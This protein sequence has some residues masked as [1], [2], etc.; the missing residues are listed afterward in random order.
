RVAAPASVA[1]FLSRPLGLGA[2]LA[3][4]IE[5]R[6]ADQRVV[7]ALALLAGDAALVSDLCQF[8][9]ALLRPAKQAGK[10]IKVALVAAP[11]ALGREWRARAM[12]SASC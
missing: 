12:T 10:Q 11:L 4:L 7:T 3:R 8:P 1:L 2:A 6:V 9:R 5:L